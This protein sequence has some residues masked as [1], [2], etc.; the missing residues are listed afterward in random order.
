MWGHGNPE[1]RRSTRTCTGAPRNSQHARERCRISRLQT[2]TGPRCPKH[3]PRAQEPTRPAPPQTERK[4]PRKRVPRTPESKGGQA[5]PCQPPAPPGDTKCKLR[6]PACVHTS[7]ARAAGPGPPAYA[8]NG[9]LRTLNRPIPQKDRPREPPRAAGPRE[10]QTPSCPGAPCC[11]EVNSSKPPADDAFCKASCETA[12]QTKLNRGRSGSPRL[13][14]AAH[15]RL[16]SWR[17]PE[18]SRPSWAPLAPAP[19]CRAATVAA[20]EGPCLVY[21]GQS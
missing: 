1:D 6:A 21:S 16:V 10:G 11:W 17:A 5:S 15:L 2:L 8:D 14:C 12:H 4:A 7:P 3:D 18:Q 20:R 9:L 19:L 13:T